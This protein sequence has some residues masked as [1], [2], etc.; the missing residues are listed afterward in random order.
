M[1]ANR[2]AVII[3]YGGMVIKQIFPFSLKLKWLTKRLAGSMIRKETFGGAYMSAADL[4]SLQEKPR[5]TPE[6]VRAVTWDYGEDDGRIYSFPPSSEHTTR[7]DTLPNPFVMPEGGYVSNLNEWN[8]QRSYMQQALIHLY[9]WSSSIVSGSG[10]G[11]NG[12]AGRRRLWAYDL[13]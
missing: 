2:P 11:K 1:A 8:R 7:I 13:L 12:G 10:L 9:I 3:A 6:D 4:R 5:F